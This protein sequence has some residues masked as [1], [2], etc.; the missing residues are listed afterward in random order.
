M[1][2]ATFSDGMTMVQPAK[3][4]TTSSFSTTALPPN[5]YQ[6]KTGAIIRNA[7]AFERAAGCGSTLPCLPPKCLPG[8][9]LKA[10]PCG[11]T[12][13]K[14]TSASFGPPAPSGGPPAPNGGPPAPPPDFGP[15]ALQ[16]YPEGTVARW[17]VKDKAWWVYLPRQVAFYGLDETPAPDVVVPGT[18]DSPP[19]G[20][21]AGARI[22]V[23]F[24]S[25]PWFWGAVAGVAV[26]GGGVVYFV[27]R[28]GK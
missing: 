11:Q 3:T 20:A 15:P 25:N 19:A 21:K 28:R 9:M 27:R 22:E 8:Y 13:V 1:Y 12:C 24:Y 6:G 17:H 4:G 26:V 18:E 5:C 7:T 16:A 23:P 2:T 14:A 10:S